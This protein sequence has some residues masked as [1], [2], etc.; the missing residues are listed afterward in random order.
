[1]DYL[2]AGMEREITMASSIN[3]AKELHDTNSDVCSGIGY[4]K[5]TFSLHVKEGIK[6]FQTLPMCVACALQKLFKKELL[7]LLE[8]Q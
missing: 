7:H 6:P 3:I 5:G 1:M 8:Q 2:I 4:F